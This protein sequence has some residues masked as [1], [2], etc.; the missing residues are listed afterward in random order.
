VLIHDRI[1]KD[2]DHLS[3]VPLKLKKMKQRNINFTAV[4][5]KEINELHN[6]DVWKKKNKLRQLELRRREEQQLLQKVR[7]LEGAKHDHTDKTQVKEPK[8]KKKK[9]VKV[10]MTFDE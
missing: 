5:L 4:P 6:Q 10:E 3:L 2:S 8:I 7:E 1:Q 9:K